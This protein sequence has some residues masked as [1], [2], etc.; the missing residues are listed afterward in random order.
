MNKS[1]CSFIK[2]WLFIF[3]KNQNS[4]LFDFSASC[5][6]YLQL[7]EI[8][9]IDRENF[10]AQYEPEVTKYMADKGKLRHLVWDFWTRGVCLCCE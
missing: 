1:A 10:D 9:F 5:K 6:P 7:L 8:D 4:I 3:K 2:S